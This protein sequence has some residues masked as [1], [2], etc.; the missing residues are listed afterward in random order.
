[1]AADY[2][3]YQGELEV[4]DEGEDLGSSVAPSDSI[5]PVI[6][7]LTTIFTIIGMLLIGWEL[8]S[9]YDGQGNPGRADSALIQ[10]KLK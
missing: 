3:D 1:M 5:T 7:I 9:V 8:F 10:I 2:E 6:I 4:I